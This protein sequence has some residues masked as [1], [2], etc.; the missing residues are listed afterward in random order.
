[1]SPYIYDLLLKIS[2]L[3]VAVSSLL[4][5]VNAIVSSK[6]LGGSLGKGLKKIT[7][8]IIAYTILIST[9]FLLST[10]NKG[11]LND[12]QIRAFFTFVGLFGSFFIIKGYLQIYRVAKRLKLFTI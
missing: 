3:M 8:G 12:D 1:M 4:V 10:G 5:I 7:I 11:L 6:Q 2:F 9:Y